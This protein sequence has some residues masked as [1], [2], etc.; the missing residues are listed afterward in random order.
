MFSKDAMSEIVVEIVESK[1]DEIAQ[2]VLEQIES[3][4][5]E[6]AEKVL[7]QIE[8]KKD[9]IESKVDDVMDKTEEKV[10]SAIEDIGKKLEDIVDKLDDNPQVAKVLDIVDDVIGDQLDGREISC[11]CFGFLWFLRISRKNKP[12][13]PSKSADTL[14]ITLPTQIPNVET[15]EQPPSNSLPESQVHSTSQ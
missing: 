13:P 15:K 11:S 7:E 14:N 6:I 9:E 8:S 4:K 3:K 5:D 1:K 2:K 10:E 12:S